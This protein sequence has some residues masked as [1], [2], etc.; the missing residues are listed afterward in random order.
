[1]QFASP[2][3]TAL[4]FVILSMTFGTELLAAQATRRHS[5]EQGSSIKLNVDLVSLSVVVTDEKGQVVTDLEQKDFKVYEDR[6]EQPLRFFSHEDGPVSWGLVLDR[7]RS[8][9]PMIQEVHQ[10]AMHLVDEGTAEDEMFILT[11]NDE[12]QLVRDFTSDR[13]QLTNSIFGLEAHGKTAVFDAVA[14]ALERLQDSRH[15]KKTLVIVT[16]GEDNRSELTFRELLE[17]AE[18]RDVMIYVIGMFEPPDLRRPRLR[19]WETRAL[20]DKLA[21]VTGGR[22]FFPDDAWDCQKAVKQIAR[23]ASHQYSLGYYPTRAPGA[24]EWRKIKVVVVRSG[25]RQQKYTIRSRARYFAP[26]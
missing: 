24:G 15:P 18:E 11:F 21:K 22:A 9:R 4:L 23:E 13:H 12:T 17:L 19:S 25:E 10:A 3:R 8:M 16:D 14:L 1:M 20:L 26:M 6:V 2:N 5:P 7:S